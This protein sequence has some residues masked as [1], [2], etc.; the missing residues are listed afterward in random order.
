MRYATP[1]P[2]LL[3]QEIGQVGDVR[4]PQ[5]AGGVAQGDVGATGAQ[6]YAHDVV[7]LGVHLL[8]RGLSTGRIVKTHVERRAIRN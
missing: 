6:H 7:T 2:A 1:L 3:P 8:E 4:S 5:S